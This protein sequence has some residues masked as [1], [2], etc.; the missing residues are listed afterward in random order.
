MGNC[1]AQSNNIV[2]KVKN[3]TFD[4]L[5]NEKSSF[6]NK[7]YLSTEADSIEDNSD[8]FNQIFND[9]SLESDD[10]SKILNISEINDEAVNKLDSF[11]KILELFD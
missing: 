8:V 9:S 3:N 5:R 11:R 4:N 7:K 6:K 2:I 1:I 10:V